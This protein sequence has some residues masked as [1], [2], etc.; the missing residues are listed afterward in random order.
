MESQRSVYPTRR[1]LWIYWT[2]TQMYCDFDKVSGRIAMHTGLQF[3]GSIYNTYKE[4]ERLEESETE[5]ERGSGSKRGWSTQGPETRYGALV[6]R[7]EEDLGSF[8][9]RRTIGVSS[10]LSN[11]IYFHFER[12]SQ[13]G[14]EYTDRDFRVPFE[15]R[16]LIYFIRLL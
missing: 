9:A 8:V 10:F 14:A 16:P 15:L 11:E 3:M 7:P 12:P 2:N 1:Q 5:K 13:P 6:T 4:T